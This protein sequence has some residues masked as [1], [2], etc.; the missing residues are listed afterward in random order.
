MYA[1]RTGENM[2]LPVIDMVATG[3]HLN[4]LRVAN[5][6]SVSSIKEYLGLNTTY[7]IYKWMHGETMPSVDNLLALSV[8]FGTSIN[9]LLI[10]RS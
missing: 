8:L 2:N 3:E 1:A 6:F 5:G 10:Y 7:A 9:D 4:A